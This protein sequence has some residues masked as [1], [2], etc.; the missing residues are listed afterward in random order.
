MEG[1]TSDD[2]TAFI[3]ALGKKIFGDKGNGRKYVREKKQNFEDRMAR[4]SHE[5]AM[6]RKAAQ[7]NQ[8]MNKFDEDDL[9]DIEDEIY[10]SMFVAPALISKQL[11]KRNK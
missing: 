6:Q 4:K 11:F 8:L 3:F 5:K 10:G 7:F 1:D 9:D 2:Y